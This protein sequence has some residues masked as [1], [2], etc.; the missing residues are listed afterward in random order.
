VVQLTYGIN[1]C[2]ITVK[3]LTERRLLRRRSIQATDSRMIGLV[4]SL[5]AMSALVCSAPNVV[6]LVGVGVEACFV[7]QDFSYAVSQRRV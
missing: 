1:S 2:P 3:R 4:T 5:Q 6:D 7:I